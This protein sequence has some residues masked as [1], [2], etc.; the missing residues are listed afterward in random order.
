KRDQSVFD[1]MTEDEFNN[2]MTFINR[3]NQ[4]L[5]QLIEQEH[6]SL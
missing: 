4:H 3:Y 1:S 2:M 6:R 5:D